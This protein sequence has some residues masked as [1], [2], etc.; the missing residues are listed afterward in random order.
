VKNSKSLIIN[1]RTSSYSGP[2]GE[3]VEVGSQSPSLIVVRDSKDP[4]GAWIE[5]SASDWRKFVVQAKTGL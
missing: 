5:V 4:A 3:C 1:F 2:E